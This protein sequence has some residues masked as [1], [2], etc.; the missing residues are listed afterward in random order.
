MA[1][2]TSK[3]KVNSAFTRGSST[4]TTKL[5]LIQKTLKELWGAICNGLKGMLLLTIRLGFKFASSSSL[6]SFK[7]GKFRGPLKIKKFFTSLHPMTRLKS[8]L[9]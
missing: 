9:P 4:I 3:I 6:K 2:H 7:S 1:F 5:Q 8:L